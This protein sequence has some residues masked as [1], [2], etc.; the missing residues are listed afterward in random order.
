LPSQIVATLSAQYDFDLGPLGDGWLVGVDGYYAEVYRGLDFVDLRSRVIGTLP[1]GRPR[2]ADFNGNNANTNQDL[3]LTNDNRGRRMIG[4]ARVRKDSTWGWDQR[5]LHLPGH[6]GRKRDHVRDGGLALR[7]QPVR[8][9]EQGGLWHVGLPDPAFDQGGHRLLQGPVRRRLPDAVLHFGERRSGRPYSFTFRD[10]VTARSPVFGTTGSSSRYLMYV[11]ASATDA[12]VSY[13]TVATQNAL[14]AFI[15]ST[16]GLRRFRGQI[17]PKNT[18]RSPNYTK[19]DLHVE[20]EIPTFIGSSRIKLFADLENFL[21]LLDSDWGVQRQVNFPQNAPLVNVQCLTAAVPTGTP[22]GNVGSAPPA[23]GVA[24]VA[25]NTTQAC[26]QYRYSAFQDPV[27]QV[28]N[29]NRQSLYQ[30]RVGV[31]FEF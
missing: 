25:T 16:G 23:G 17:V 29:N 22:V 5:Q 31:R 19:V 21:N 28:Q 9:S 15:D 11:P 12:L 7:K 30:I 3:L 14:N 2:Y 4:V 20:Q 26:A 13:D 6:R 18:A 1:D 10:P 24:A 8:R 27:I